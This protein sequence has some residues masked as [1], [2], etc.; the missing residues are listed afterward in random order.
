[1]HLVS[2]RNENCSTYAKGDTYNNVFCCLKYVSPLA[3]DSDG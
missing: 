3:K 1:M 2:I